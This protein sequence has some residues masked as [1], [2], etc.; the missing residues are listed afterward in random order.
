MIREHVRL[1]RGFASRVADHPSLELVAPVP[2]SLVCFRHVD[3]DDATTRLAHAI[4]D[5]GQ[6]YVTPSVLDG[7]SFI[8]VS[9]GQTRTN[10]THVD[11]LWE[12]I[13]GQV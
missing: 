9:I 4:N 8:R 6:S 13:A 2:F 12:L 1:A 3:G 7:R 10:V 11:R 5:S